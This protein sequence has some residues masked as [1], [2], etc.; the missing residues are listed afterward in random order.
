L[1]PVTGIPLS[2]IGATVMRW[3]GDYP[4][5]REARTLAKQAG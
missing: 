5:V 1:L 4:E 2:G 3:V